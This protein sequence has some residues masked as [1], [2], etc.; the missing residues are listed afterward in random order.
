MERTLSDPA[1]SCSACSRVSSSMELDM[2]VDHY[3]FGST[4]KGR[5]F[6]SEPISIRPV[7]DAEHSSL[8]LFGP[9]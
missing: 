4:C 9:P 5:I 8:V 2:R 6:R 3:P 1:F 7:A